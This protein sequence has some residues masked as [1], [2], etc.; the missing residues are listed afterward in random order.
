MGTINYE[1]LFRVQFQ[2][3][4]G[5]IFAAVCY[6]FDKT[7]YM[8]NKNKIKLHRLTLFFIL[9]STWVCAHIYFVQVFIFP[10]GYQFYVQ[11]YMYA[12]STQKASFVCFTAFI[13]R[14]SV[15]TV[16]KEVT[17]STKYLSSVSKSDNLVCNLSDC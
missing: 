17:V 7:D 1:G 12:F 3:S 8:Y 11:I 2:Q 9:K 4:V 15:Q 6:L 14:L 10:E 5:Y 13:K 16:Q